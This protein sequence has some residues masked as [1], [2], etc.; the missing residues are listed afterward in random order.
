MQHTLNILGL[1]IR[2]EETRRGNR[3]SV[4]WYE[5]LLVD[6]EFFSRGYC[7]DFGEL[8]KSL[9]SDGEFY[10]LTCECGEPGC[11]GVTD[12]V[13]VRH[14]PGLVHWHV[15]FPKPERHLS[16]SVAQYR[17]AVCTALTAADKAI[18]GK[19][20]V[21]IGPGF[22]SRDKFRSY[23]RRAERACLGS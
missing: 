10:F 4:K 6:D 11:V 8:V 18:T 14:S 13:I 3:A 16:F 12:G 1:E 22:V 20:H 9:E 23:V 17:E 19:G 5:R 7:L 15:R 2:R 21:P